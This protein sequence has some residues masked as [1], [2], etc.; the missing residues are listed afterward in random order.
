MDE[1]RSEASSLAQGWLVVDDNFGAVPGEEF[2]LV[3]AGLTAALAGEAVSLTMVA[4]G[5]SARRP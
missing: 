3:D 2:R 4:V 1:G 5:F